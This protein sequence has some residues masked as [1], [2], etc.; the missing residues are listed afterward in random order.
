MDEIIILVMWKGN[1]NTDKRVPY[2]IN[3]LERLK[4]LPYLTYVNDRLFTMT[5]NKEILKIFKPIVREMNQQSFID[6]INANNK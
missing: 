3:N 2:S 1:I 6:S 4:K 5:H